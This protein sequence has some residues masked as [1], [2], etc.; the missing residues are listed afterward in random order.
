MQ[1]K[2]KRIAKSWKL[3]HWEGVKLGNSEVG[4]Y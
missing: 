4:K 2:E 1:G 3:G